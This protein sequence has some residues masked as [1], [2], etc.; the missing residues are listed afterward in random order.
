LLRIFPGKG[1]SYAD[2]WWSEFTNYLIFG[3][4][5]AFFIWLAL[6]SVG[7]GTIGPEMMSNAAIKGSAED[8]RAFTASTTIPTGAG[9][10]G[11]LLSFVIAICMLVAGTKIAGEMGAVGAG[12]MNNFRGKLG[13]M[14]VGAAKTLT[15]Y[16]YGEALVKLRQQ[17]KQDAFQGRVA[18]VQAGLGYV[19]QGIGT[20][21]KYGVGGLGV[22]AGHAVFGRRAATAEGKAKEL[23]QEATKARG[24][25]DF[26]GAEKHEQAATA[27]RARAA[28]LRKGQRWTERGVNATV[29]GVA[30]VATGGVGAVLIPGMFGRG[31]QGAGKKNVSDAKQYVYK[32]VGGERD[33]V[34]NLK[35]ED[36]LKKMQGGP[37][38]SKF[39]QMAAMIA[40]VEKQLVS[41]S[42]LKGMEAKL[43]SFGADEKTISTFQ[44]TADQ[45]YPGTRLT[46]GERKRRVEAGTMPTKDLGATELAGDNGAL[47]R[48]FV[49]SGTA[50]QRKDLS[51]SKTLKSAYQ[52]GLKAAI[53]G[54]TDPANQQ[55][56]QAELMR[57]GGDRATGQSALQVSG[58]DPAALGKALQ[59]SLSSELLANIEPTDI[60]GSTGSAVLDA[61]V[62]NVNAARL[63]A[64]VGAAKKPEAD[65]QTAVNL[66]ALQDAIKNSQGAKD[67]ET[68][69][70]P[71]RG[72]ETDVASA[73]KQL[74]KT[75]AQAARIPPTSPRAGA[76]ATQIARLTGE[77]TAAEANLATAQTAFEARVA[78]MSKTEQ[79]LYEAMR[80][81]KFK[82]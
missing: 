2:K 31:L 77:L 4:V 53:G 80:R 44:S 70:A 13:Q 20:G 3:P 33:A 74:D 62:K 10:P 37:D 42:D 66:A 69:H 75:R 35:P 24:K 6:V 54:E 65:P 76:L 9:N 38:V 7:S 30:T 46:P 79:D 29:A 71:V 47:A 56:L 18:K 82:K 39:E 63:G 32:K 60:T 26:V 17:R 25:G 19:Q 64:A 68:A 21:L 81:A 8:E 14:G 51:T 40:A 67:Y 28:S 58:M 73:K 36:I 5:V 16:R 15:G 34:K 41:G 61:I 48:D 78:T 72:A 22:G 45:K 1:K 57:L 43:R 27:A 50:S 12:A 52:A 55:K 49:L 11:S 59:G 23:S